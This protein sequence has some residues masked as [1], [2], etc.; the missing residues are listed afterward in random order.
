MVLRNIKTQA[1]ACT[2]VRGQAETQLLIFMIKSNFLE[3]LGWGPRGSPIIRE[4]STSPCKA[5]TT[6]PRSLK[7]IKTGRRIVWRAP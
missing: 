7:N 4:L 1:F 2:I 3:N 6:P 5:A